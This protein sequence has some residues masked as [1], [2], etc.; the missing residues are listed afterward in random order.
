MQRAREV[1]DGQPA[2]VVASMERELKGLSARRIAAL[3]LAYKG[4]VDDLRN[5]PALEVA[6]LL[7]AKG[8][9]VSTFE[10][11][12]P[13][14]APEGCTP[15]DSLADAVKDADAV[16]LLVDHRQF[17]E[18]DPQTLAAQMP[19]RVAFDTRGVWSSSVW[20][21]AGFQLHILGVRSPDA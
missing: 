12:A 7:A 19:G 15:A 13:E 18:L 5:S 14:V 2:F 21:Q 20:E 4:D 9:K 11:F 1:N 10:P 3:G 8:A 16:A 6:R 17:R